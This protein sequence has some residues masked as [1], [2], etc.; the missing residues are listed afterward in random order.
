[1]IALADAHAHLCDPAFDPD[2]AQ[3]LERARA[4]GITA[5]VSVSEDLSDAE[6]NLELASRHPMIRPAAELYPTDLPPP[7]RGKIR[8]EPI[9]WMVFVRLALT[10]V[11][12]LLFRQRHP[13]CGKN[14]LLPP[15]RSWQ[16]RHRGIGI[17]GVM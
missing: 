10:N 9:R 2:L 3:V 17:N 11:S 14:F 13:E 16:T 4:C 1:M 8:S 6:K 5:A 15:I 7:R 12:C